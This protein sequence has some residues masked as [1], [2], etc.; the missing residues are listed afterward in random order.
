MRCKGRGASAV[1]VQLRPTLRSLDRY[2]SIFRQILNIIDI[3]NTTPRPPA[4]ATDL[5]PR[6][7]LGEEQAVH[8]LSALAHP[9]R[10]RI[11][12]A[13]V[14]VGE[15]GLTPGAMAPGVDVAPATLSHHLKDLAHAGLVSA[16]RQGRHLVYRAAFDRMNELLAYLTEHCCQGDPCDA[17]A[18]GPACRSLPCETAP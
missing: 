15:P 16:R 4:P 11:F 5:A 18:T 1:M 8:A 9:V 6:S 10:L 12:R 2:H 3:V 17:T 14:V 7:P 13:L